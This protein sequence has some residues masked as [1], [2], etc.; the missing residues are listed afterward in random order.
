MLEVGLLACR[1]AGRSSVK[2]SRGFEGC[3]LSGVLAVP[4]LP[5]AVPHSRSSEPMLRQISV[6]PGCWM[7]W[8]SVVNVGEVQVRITLL[9]LR[10]AWRSVTGFA[11]SR[12]GGRGTPGLPQEESRPT[13]IVQRLIVLIR[14]VA[15]K[16]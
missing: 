10:M 15:G 9:P 2:L 8:R 7:L 3:L 12:E 1:V 11:S 13:A 5:T 16:D 14:I 6:S 4:T